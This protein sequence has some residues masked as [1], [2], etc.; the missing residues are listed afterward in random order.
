MSKAFKDFMAGLNEGMTQ[1]EGDKAAVEEEIG[2][3]KA[4]MR[5]KSLKERQELSPETAKEVSWCATNDMH[6]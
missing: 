4:K 2:K 1:Q 6:S 3:A 5:R